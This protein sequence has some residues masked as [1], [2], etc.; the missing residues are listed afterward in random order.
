MPRWYLCQDVT[1]QLDGSGSATLTAGA[2]DNGSSDACGIQ[3]AVLSQ[4]SFSCGDVGANTVTLT[5][6][7]V[8]GNTS[9]VRTTVTVED[10]IAPVVLCAR[11]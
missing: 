3:S 1:V 9:P 5:V 2:V 4:Q 10:N 8:N 7:D 11:M 6:T